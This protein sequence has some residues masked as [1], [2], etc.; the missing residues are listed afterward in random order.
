MHVVPVKMQIQP[1]RPPAQP[2]HFRLSQVAFRSVFRH[3]LRAFRHS[4]PHVPEE[5][6][7]LPALP[8]FGG[9]VFSHLVNTKILKSARGFKQYMW[10]MIDECA[11][12]VQCIWKECR[13]CAL[14]HKGAGDDTKTAG[15][16]PVDAIGW[17]W[18]NRLCDWLITSRCS[19]VVLTIAERKKSASEGGRTADHTVGSRAP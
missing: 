2:H 5:T 13:M 4:F 14:W 17:W 6:I 19:R 9:T 18:C 16:E 3:F 7:N 1:T 11:P 10:W 12:S 8:A 15:A